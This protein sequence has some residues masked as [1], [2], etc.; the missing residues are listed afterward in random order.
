[1]NGFDLHSSAEEYICRVRS[2]DGEK[3]AYKE[4]SLRLVGCAEVGD[5]HSASIA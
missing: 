3:Y 1:M 2:S 4:A 5:W